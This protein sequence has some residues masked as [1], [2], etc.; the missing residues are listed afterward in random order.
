MYTGQ[1]TCA[2]MESITK[3]ASLIVLVSTHAVL[4]CMI[5]KVPYTQ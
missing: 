3:A 2:G 4:H 5:G 1:H